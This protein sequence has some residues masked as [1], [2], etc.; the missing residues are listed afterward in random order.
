MSPGSLEDTPLTIT[1][2]NETLKY[3][4]EAFAIHHLIDDCPPFT[5]V[6][7]LVKIAEENASQ[8]SPP[9]RV[10]WF[11]EVI[12]GVRKIGLFNEGPGMSAEDLSRLMDLASTGKTLGTQL[13]Y[14]QGAKVS[15]L[16][17]SPEGVVYRSCKA[18]QIC[19]IV[20]A[21]ECR[22]EFD[23]PVYVKRRQMVTDDEG[24]SW[25]T[26]LDVTDAYRDR[27]DRPLSADW[28]E[29]VLLGR[30]ASHNTTADLNHRAQSR[31][32]LHYAG[33]QGLAIAF[34]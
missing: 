16:K 33:S 4:N 3:R 18:G 20:L 19:Q 23:F 17:V 6:R 26:V 13:N 15:A 9:G 10:E 27:E 2:R 1:V 22:P 12:D 21:G 5:V 34:A 24:R 31:S 14:G 30:D 28:T 7:E 25:E 8:N 29:V 32:C 11:I